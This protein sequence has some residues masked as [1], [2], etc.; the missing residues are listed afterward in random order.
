MVVFHFKSKIYMIKHEINLS[1]IV[2]E[3]F[4]FNDNSMSMSIH[5]PIAQNYFYCCCC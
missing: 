2:I 3:S 4:D 5:D 1:F